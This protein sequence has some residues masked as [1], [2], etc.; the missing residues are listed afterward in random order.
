MEVFHFA[1]Y[2]DQWAMKLDILLTTKVTK[3]KKKTQ[4]LHNL[5]D[6]TKVSMGHRGAH[7]AVVLY[8][9]E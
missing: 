6:H 5:V 3:L 7:Y 9:P 1:V 4:I 2:R 8:L